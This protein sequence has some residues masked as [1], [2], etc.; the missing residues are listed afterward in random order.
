MPIC[1]NCCIVGKNGSLGLGRHTISLFG[2]EFG[3]NKSDTSQTQYDKCR[4]LIPNSNINMK[5]TKAD[6]KKLVGIYGLGEQRGPIA[7]GQLPKMSR[8]LFEF[9]KKMVDVPRS[10]EETHRKIVLTSGGASC[11]MFVG[12]NPEKASEIILRGLNAR[13]QRAAHSLDAAGHESFG[14]QLIPIGQSS[15]M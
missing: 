3:S 10:V 15:Q 12:T 7:N 11:I 1:K 2:R 14:I 9:I 13:P 4:A 6:I 5:I 8:S